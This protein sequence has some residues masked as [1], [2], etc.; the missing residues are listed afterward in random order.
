MKLIY[1]KSYNKNIKYLKNRVFEKKLLDEI[2]YYIKKQPNF[3]T[4]IN[5][6]LSNLYRLERLKYEL[7]DYYSFRL[8]KVIR[9]IIKPS[10]N[11]IEVYL[12]YISK[13]HYN[14]F[15]EDKVILDEE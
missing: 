2:L 5:D 10:D 13:D 15:S 3:S 8:S 6:P 7:S 9:L 4:M 12:V 1:T 11:N 14:D